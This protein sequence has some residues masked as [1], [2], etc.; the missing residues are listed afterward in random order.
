LN[1]SATCYTHYTRMLNIFDLSPAWVI[2][3]ILYI[4]YA[5]QKTS[6]EVGWHL[7]GLALNYH[8][9]WLDVLLKADPTLET[10][11]RDKVVCYTKV[12]HALPRLMRQPGLKKLDQSPPEYRWE[13]VVLRMTPTELLPMP[14]G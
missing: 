4:S 7:R 1:H 9:A 6:S 13:S 11:V 14:S 10:K 8:Q 2:I 12:P 3:Y 5:F